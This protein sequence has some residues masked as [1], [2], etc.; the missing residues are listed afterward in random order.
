MKINV[1]LSKYAV[2]ICSDVKPSLQP[3]YLAMQRFIQLTPKIYFFEKQGK[4]ITPKGKGL[5]L[6]KLNMYKPHT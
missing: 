6:L 1:F 2:Y 4:K 3:I 5:F